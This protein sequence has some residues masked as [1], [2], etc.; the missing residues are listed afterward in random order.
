[1]G[2][3]PRQGEETIERPEKGAAT[4]SRCVDDAVN[5]CFD[6]DE[7]DSSY[8]NTATVSETKEPYGPPLP[9]RGNLCR[10]QIIID[11]RQLR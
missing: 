4:T 9:T 2:I 6:S 11:P 5:L 10:E 1:M 3:A 8:R 7:Q